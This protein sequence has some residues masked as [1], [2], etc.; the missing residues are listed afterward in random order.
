[1]PT[2]FYFMGYSVYFMSNEGMPREPLHVHISKNV[3]GK[4][5]K[6]WI[7]KDGTCVV[8]HNDAK[9][10]RAALNKI[11]KTLPLWQ[12]DIESYWERF[13]HAVPDYYTDISDRLA[14][15]KEQSSEINR[16]RA[17]GQRSR[18]KGGDGR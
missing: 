9:I 14:E 5:T 18:S 1:M 6:I 4:S 15:K 16:N 12:K 17:A 3:G 7:K 8:A 2:M 11:L 13:F 10:G